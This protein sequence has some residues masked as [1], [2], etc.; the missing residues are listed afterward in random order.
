MK[1]QTHTKLVLCSGLA[2]ALSW[3][4]WLPGSAQSADPAGEKMMEHC[5]A[6]KVQKQKMQTDMQAQ[7]DQLSRQLETMNRA[8]REEKLELLAAVVTEMVE[9]QTTTNARK[10]KMDEEMMKHQMQHMQMGKESMAECP[11]MKGMDAKTGDA[12]KDH[13]G[14]QK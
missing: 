13:Q 9:Q 3:A 8:P 11:M 7:S 12:H 5:R 2:L 14:K 1:N 10:A 4:V 6:M